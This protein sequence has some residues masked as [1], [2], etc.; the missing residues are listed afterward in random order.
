ME[1]LQSSRDLAI[2]AAAPNGFTV[3]SAATTLRPDQNKVLVIIPLATADDYDI[4]LP[5]VA[6]CPG[7]R[8]VFVCKRATGSYV[9]GGVRV[10][11]QND[12]WVV[13]NLTND[14]MTVAT[15]DYWVVDNIEGLFWAQVSEI[16]T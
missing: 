16:T 4:T 13:D 6:S 7:R 12:G 5:P 8:F 9:D 15:T 11:D 14:K 2:G 10:V 3:V 1:Q